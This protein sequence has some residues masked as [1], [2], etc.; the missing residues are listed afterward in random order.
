MRITYRGQS[1]NVLGYNRATRK[2]KI[3]LVDHPESRIKYVS[4]SYRV[5]GLTR[6]MRELLGIA[7]AVRINYYYDSSYFEKDPVVETEP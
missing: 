2:L 7:P 1:Y 6:E 5:A 3:R 4:V